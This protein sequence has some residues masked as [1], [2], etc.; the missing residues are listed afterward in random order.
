M[1]TNDTPTTEVGGGGRYVENPDFVPNPTHQFGTLDTSGTAGAAHSKVEEVSPIF[2]VA[3]RQELATAARALDP[4]DTEV[5]ASLVNLPKGAYIAAADPGEAVDRV[6]ATA[7]AYRDAPVQV[8]GLTPAQRA[9]AEED[10]DKYVESE[11]DQRAN[12]G[13]GTDT[14][15]GTGSTVADENSGPAVGGTDDPEQASADRAASATA[16]TEAEQKEAEAK[17]ASTAPSSEKDDEK[18]HRGRGSK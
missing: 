7:E 5:P 4:E 18:A 16:T 12:S 15:Q 13:A 14:A 1:P 17:K 3:K 10:D 2:E 8:G 11:A 9:A 6:K